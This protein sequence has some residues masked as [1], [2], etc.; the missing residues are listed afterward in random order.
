LALFLPAWEFHGAIVKTGIESISLIQFQIKDLGSRNTMGSLAYLQVKADGREKR[1]S[2]RKYKVAYRRKEN[3]LY[4]LHL[5][6][7]REA[8]GV[9]MLP[10]VMSGSHVASRG[11]RWPQGIQMTLGVMDD[12]VGLQIASG[13]AGGFVGSW[14][15][16]RWSLG[17][18]F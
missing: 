12:F 3:L 8:S 15:G 5:A 4:S 16:R 7:L 6:R 11:C 13:S 14:G 2:K 18:C 17:V 9:C 10:W 1:K